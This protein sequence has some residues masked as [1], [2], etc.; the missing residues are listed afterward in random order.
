MLKKIFSSV[1]LGAC[2]FSANAF[3]LPQIIISPPS[4]TIKLD[5]SAQKDFDTMVEDFHTLCDRDYKYFTSDYVYHLAFDRK[6]FISSIS[7]ITINPTGNSFQQQSPSKGKF[8]PF[9]LQT[10]LDMGTCITQ[11]DM[12]GQ[13]DT[14]LSIARDLQRPSRSTYFYT[15]DPTYT[16]SFEYTYEIDSGNVISPNNEE[17]FSFT[18]NHAWDTVDVSYTISGDINFTPNA[19]P[20]NPA[21]Q[22]F[23]IK[24]IKRAGI[25]LPAPKTYLQIDPSVQPTFNQMISQIAT[26]CGVTAQPS[27]PSVFL[28]VDHVGKAV[29][30]V[31]SQLPNIFLT[32][33]FNWLPEC[34]Q[35]PQTSLPV[36][37]TMTTKDNG[38]VKSVIAKVM[39]PTSDETDG[40]PFFC[41]SQLIT[42]Y[43]QLFTVDVKY[44]SSSSPTTDIKY[45]LAGQVCFGIQID[46]TVPSEQTFII[47]SIQSQ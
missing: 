38:S 7:A 25:Y 11:V 12:G 20:T 44:T 46:P 1:I 31:D 37:Y 14:Y 47:R 16:A 26:A 10:S 45:T 13:K 35:L 24:S 29:G 4:A 9:I 15:T 22:I 39:Y 41:P 6:E 23:V 19:D 36:K 21:D 32:T 8:Q 30:T 28:L 2:L 5:P 42:S 33:N 3:S 27:P 17:K 40:Y 34:P 18:I 43:G